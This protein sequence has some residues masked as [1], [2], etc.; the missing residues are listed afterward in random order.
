MRVCHWQTA[1]GYRKRFTIPTDSDYHVRPSSAVPGWLAVRS[2]CNATYALKMN[3][4]FGVSPIAWF[5][6]ALPHFGNDM[7]SE[8]CLAQARE[9]GFSG[10]EGGPG[11]PADEQLGLLL[12]RF[13]LALMAGRFQGTLLSSSVAEEKDRMQPH[14]AACKALG[15]S[16]LL[17]T[18]TSGS[19]QSRFDTPASLRPRIG[20]EEFPGY[21]A[22]LTE[23]ADWVANS[24]IAL[25][26]QHQMGSIIQ[27]QREIDL[28]IQHTG[29]V[30]KLLIDT[31]HLAYAGADMPWL[32]RRHADRINLVHCK[33]V[34]PEVLKRVRQRDTSLPAAVLDG[35]FTVPGDGFIDFY[36]FARLL[37]EVGYAGWIVVEAEQDPVKAPPLEYSRMGLR[38]LTDAFG[39]AGYA[40]AP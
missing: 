12:E 29:P 30:L 8:V 37:V 16:T 38:H 4:R 10:I 33:D 25:A 14:V 19:I 5:N 13:G 9:A 17:Y 24:G 31:G 11:L 26:Y 2:H 15:A 32:T 35:V 39:S 34:R 28:L 40:F 22:K 36:S 27:T 23:L 1:T 18:D 3:V 6:S 20:D 21:G 7:T